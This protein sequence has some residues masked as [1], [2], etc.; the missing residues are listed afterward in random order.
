MTKQIEPCSS[1]IDHRLA[2]ECSLLCC[3]LKHL[4]YLDRARSRKPQRSSGIRIPSFARSRPRPFAGISSKGPGGIGQESPD[5]TSFAPGGIQR[6]AAAAAAT[7]YSRGSVAELDLRC[8]RR[9]PEVTTRSGAGTSREP[10]HNSSSPRSRFRKDPIRSARARS[11]SSPS[12]IFFFFTVS[13]G[14]GCRLTLSCRPAVR[15]FR[16]Y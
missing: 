9:W 13:A 11:P 3:S 1:W 14:F 7:A 16:N 5:G 6:A 4:E 8:C 15:S 12:W 2:L 10:Q